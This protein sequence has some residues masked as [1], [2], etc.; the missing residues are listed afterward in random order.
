MKLNKRKI[1]KKNIDISKENKEKN[2][3][4]FLKGKVL[5]K[6]R[7]KGFFEIKIPNNVRFVMINGLHN[8]EVEILKK[9]YKE[10]LRIFKGRVFYSTNSYVNTLAFVFENDCKRFDL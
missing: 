7:T 10:V 9:D 3:A 1:H 6:I 8:Y 2:L 5:K 4:I